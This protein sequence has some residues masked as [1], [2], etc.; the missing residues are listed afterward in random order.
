[1]V[2]NKAKLPK[3]KEEHKVIRKTA[4]EGSQKVIKPAMTTTILNCHAELQLLPQLLAQPQVIRP[5]G[6]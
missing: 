2:N 1:M 4:C 3:K 6:I 5:T